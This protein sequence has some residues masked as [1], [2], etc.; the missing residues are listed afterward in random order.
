MVLKFLNQ[1]K[2]PAYDTIDDEEDF[3]EER[4]VSLIDTSHKTDTHSSL[5]TLS[6]E[7]L[8]SLI[9]ERSAS[10]ESYKNAVSLLADQIVQSSAQEF[11][12]NSKFQQ[13]S[14][15]YSSMQHTEN[16]TEYEAH[17]R[18]TASYQAKLSA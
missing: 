14:S 9:E 5:A 15:A 18:Q 7:K 17:Y 8:M 13:S 10:R 12:K 11:E 2:D 16:S 6:D 4:I 1:K 3:E